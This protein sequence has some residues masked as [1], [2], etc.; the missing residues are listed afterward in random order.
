M[1]HKKI[2]P[3]KGQNQKKKCVKKKEAS[4]KKT[5]KEREVKGNPSENFASKNCKED[6]FAATKTTI[7]TSTGEKFT[8][9]SFA[10]TFRKNIDLTKS[11]IK[12]IKSSS[13]SSSSRYLTA[14]GVSTK[15][16]KIISTTNE[17]TPKG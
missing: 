8:K 7:P 13:P 5:Q 2:S 9:N 16:D 1:K 4:K 12:K 6:R 3:E 17:R 14:K 15:K 11:S 10:E